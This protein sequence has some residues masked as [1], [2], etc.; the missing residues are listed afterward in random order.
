MASGFRQ[1][2]VEDLRESRRLL[3]AFQRG[4][5]AQF[6]QQAEQ[7]RKVSIAPILPFCRQ[8][9]TEVLRQGAQDLIDMGCDHLVFDLLP[10]LQVLDERPYSRQFR[11]PSEIFFW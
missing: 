10:M 5:S 7:L 11:G 2:R 9:S 6:T 4:L 1:K 3:P 8:I